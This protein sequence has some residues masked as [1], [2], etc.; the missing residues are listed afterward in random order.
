MTGS[1]RVGSSE[2]VEFGRILIAHRQPEVETPQR[3]TASIF[4]S[5]IR[6][7]AT[8]RYT[9]DHP[10]PISLALSRNSFSPSGAKCIAVRK[11]LT[12]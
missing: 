11:S 4:A 1:A 7:A 2:W 8:D 9:P 5:E 12:L 3:K 6:R 10:M